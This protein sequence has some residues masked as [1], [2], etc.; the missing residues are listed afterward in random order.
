MDERA[1]AAAKAVGSGAVSAFGG[2]LL[3]RAGGTV[4][5]TLGRRAGPGV[6]ATGRGGRRVDDAEDA[7]IDWL[8]KGAKPVESSGSDLMLRSADGTRTI[9]FDLVNSHGDAPHINIQTWMRRNLF[10][11]DGRMIEKSNKHIYPK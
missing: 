1:A 9:R 5:S 10:P 8:G 6:G 4:V 7:I 3:K 2:P 11:G